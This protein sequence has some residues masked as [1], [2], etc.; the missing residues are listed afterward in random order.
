MAK[1]KE[2]WV[3]PCCAAHVD[4]SELGLYAE[5]R[6]PRCYYADRVHMQ[7]GNFRLEG[8]LGVGGMSVVYRALDV[9]LNRPVALKVLNDTFRGQPERIERFENESAMMARVRHENVTSVYSAG[10]AYGQFYIAMELVDGT[11]LEHMVS[12]EEPLGASAAL[13]IVRQVAMGL[14]AASEAGLLHRDMKPGNILITRGD[15]VKVIDFGLA[16]ADTA[17][18]TEEV[19]WA[20]PYYVPPETLRRK[21][22]D[23]R[24]DIYALGM[25]LR[26]MLTGVE[27]FPVQADSVSALLNCKRHLPPFAQQRPDANP[28][29]CDLVDHMTQYSMAGRPSNYD[30]LLDEIGEVQ[31]AL[32][33]DERR[34]R[35]KLGVPHLLGRLALLGAVGWLGYC[36]ACVVA[37]WHETDSQK[38]SPVVVRAEQVDVVP[39][40]IGQLRS[41]IT[42]IG[43]EK[44]DEAVEQLL[45]MSQRE[46]DPCVAAW[47]AYLVRVLAR[48]VP[49]RDGYAKAEAAQK[50]LDQLLAIPHQTSP[51][52]AVFWEYLRTHAERVDPQP[53]DW[54]NGKDGWP[55]QKSDQLSPQL[56]QDVVRRG[57][58]LPMLPDKLMEL[59]EMALWHGREDIIKECRTRLQGAPAYMKDY[60]ELGR[61][62]QRVMQERL[63]VRRI[64]KTEGEMDRTMSR[65]HR[66]LPTQADVD[67]LARI[68]NDQELPMRLRQ[69]AGIRSEAAQVGMHMGQLFMR[70]VPDKLRADM[71]LGQ[72]VDTVVGGNGLRIS[73]KTAELAHPA[74]HAIDGNKET[75]WC[76]VNRALGLHVTVRLPE[77][78]KV[79]SVVFHWE[80]NAAQTYRIQ[81]YCDGHEVQTSDVK[82]NADSSRVVFESQ[83][84]D[85]IRLSLMETRLA[86]A[87]VREIEFF[88]EKGKQIY[89]PKHQEEESKLPRVVLE[90]AQAVA[91]I[92]EEDSQAESLLL[93]ITKRKENK[94]NN[95]RVLAVSWLK[96][97]REG[98]DAR[99]AAAEPLEGN[100]EERLA[101]LFDRV[102][103]CCLVRV[104]EGNNLAFLNMPEVKSGGLNL[105]DEQQT[106]FLQHADVVELE[107]DQPLP[108]YGLKGDR[109]NQ[110]SLWSGYLQPVPQ[111]TAEHF[112]ETGSGVHIRTE[113]QFLT[114]LKDKQ[115][116]P[117]PFFFRRVP[118]YN[119]SKKVEQ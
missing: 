37:R 7:L 60:A 76:A 71:S 31:R 114:Q 50:R 109:F 57:C 79:G 111:T 119:F 104:K 4:I 24:T 67:A 11:N 94:K 27:V 61:L 49:V 5:V 110:F 62:F 115:D 28:V 82:K 10:R 91:A 86:W 65:L 26:Y 59:A 64:A 1:G 16:L 46:Q 101:E 42:K 78:E 21:P 8:V 90:D 44:F 88:D 13:E 116:N 98:R 108:V 54:Y 74:K 70:K 102:K 87:S 19:I 18:D 73:S 3:C 47:A 81:T 89:L 39:P 80:N 92:L 45:I 96:R 35:G 95:F 77:K 36:M 55:A 41:A 53:V 23:V 33:G 43:A 6:C 25:T 32:A 83:P 97:L 117:T 85:E 68:A 2:I 51:S 20:T 100:R 12:L 112:I 14:R 99:W 106:V 58:P 105:L 69:L 66:T 75:R 52:T 113:E 9:T 103:R 72:M 93:D 34:G 63:S 38:G 56:A 107:D 17:G 48:T 84:I 15:R 118:V 30:E 29:L 40:Q 22:E